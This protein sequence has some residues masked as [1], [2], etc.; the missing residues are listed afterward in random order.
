MGNPTSGQEATDHVA[1]ILREA[2]RAG[3][4]APGHRLVEF[5]LADRYGVTRAAVRGA[6]LD[7]TG[8]GLV[9]RIA[10]RGAR[11]R[12]IPLEEA[13]QIVECRAALEGLCAARAAEH[14]QDADRE[15]LRAIGAGMREAV[16]SGD[17]MSYSKLNQQLHAHILRL[18]GQKVAAGLLERLNAQIVRHQFRLSLRP[19]R[20]QTSLPEHLALIEA[21]C[22]GDAP[23]AERAAREHLAS[24][25]EALRR[26]TEEK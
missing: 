15:L 5:D 18:S 24:V 22:S 4:M 9:E 12:V 1:K 23:A 26:S 8:E 3:E 14:V 16:G 7:L 2:I 6:L 20:P 25:A 21:V 10:N 11:V 19:G 13:V 17:V